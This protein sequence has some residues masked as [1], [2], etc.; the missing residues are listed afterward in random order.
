MSKA[1]AT[2]R[3][4]SRSASTARARFAHARAHR[5]EGPPAPARFES[6]SW[7]LA[8]TFR[9]AA[10]RGRRTVRV[11]RAQL[12]A[13]HSSRRERVAD[14]RL[15]LRVVRARTEKPETR[16]IAAGATL[17]GA[18]FVARVRSR[19]E[20]AVEQ[21]GRIASAVTRAFVIAQCSTRG[22]ARCRA[23]HE[24]PRRAAATFG[25]AGADRGGEERGDDR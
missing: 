10:R 9:R 25:Q 4:R 13:E 3:S 1:M 7:H 2:S 18:R 19:G 16:G 12:R 24:I 5:K 14:C 22:A 17:T 20:A 11:L 8:Q 6:L 23:R 15:A 21:R